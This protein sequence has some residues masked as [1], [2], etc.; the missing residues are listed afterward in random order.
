MKVVSNS[1]P[2]IA[3][4]KLGLTGLLHSLYGN[5]LI[6]SAVFD[7]A[8]TR[9]VQRG[10]PDALLT[11]L[12]IARGE[13]SVGSLRESEL[14]DEFQRLKLDTGERQ[15]IFLAQ[16]EQADWLLLSFE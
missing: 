12:A 10:E 8:V 4:G 7:E 3:L 11:Q 15:A 1:G 5:V 9:G 16:R 6:P 13:V 14:P 2:L